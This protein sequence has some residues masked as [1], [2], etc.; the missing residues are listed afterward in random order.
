MLQVYRPLDTLLNE[1]PC[2]EYV[3][4]PTLSLILALI[5]MLSVLSLL[6]KFTV[7]EETV[8]LEIVGEILSLF[9]IEILTLCVTLFPAASW[10]GRVNVS[11]AVPYE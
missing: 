5:V 3:E 4:I 6:Y 2:I 9:V 7:D 1:A 11:V 10:I 8:K